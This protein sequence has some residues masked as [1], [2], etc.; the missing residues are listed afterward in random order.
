MFYVVYFSL[1]RLVWFDSCLRLESAF[2][3][4]MSSCSRHS[5]HRHSARR[6]GRRS[7]QSAFSR[8]P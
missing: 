2:R 6:G 3:P 4:K 7:A 8:L 5:A 1:T